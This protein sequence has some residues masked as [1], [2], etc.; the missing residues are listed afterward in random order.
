MKE[1]K[2]E[3]T[4]SQLS[5]VLRTG[6]NIAI[7]GNMGQGKTAIIRAYAKETGKKLLVISLAME[8]PE[9]IGGIPY[10][11]T[12]TATKVEYFTKL[13]DKRLIPVVA[14]KGKDWVIFLDEGN[15]GI[16]EVMNTLYGTAHPDPEERNWA[17]HPIPYAQVILAGNLSDGTDGTVYLTELPDPL[18]D[19]FYVM[20]LKPNRQDTIDY[21]KNKYRNIPQVS[22]YITTMLDGGINPRNTE[23]VLKDMLELKTD[24]ALSILMESKIGQALATEICNIQENI[25]SVDPSEMIKHAKTAYER[26]KTRGE[27]KSGDKMITTVE[28]FKESLSAYLSD[29]EIEAVLKG[30]E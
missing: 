22:K 7:F 3:V 19:R 12:D 4:P 1:I 5:M 21:L 20:K 25:K 27:V 26:L 29:E 13:I 11:Q 30:D 8:I 23:L 6:R 18:L 28:E 24:P 15:Q 16:P 9:T 14:D 10:A 2:T 17:G